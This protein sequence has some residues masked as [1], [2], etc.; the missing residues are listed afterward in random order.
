MTEEQILGVV[1]AVL[2]SNALTAWVSARTVR[3]RTDAET[4]STQVTTASK[5]V[6]T[7]NHQLQFAL[8]R[9]EKLE[10]AKEADR[11]KIHVLERA[12]DVDEQ[13]I[14]VLS[15]RITQLESAMAS[16]GLEIPPV[17]A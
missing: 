8:A 9:I 3:K 15:R 16:N 7:I 14:A 10:A 5:L 11:E 17:L 6:D 2:G 12:K 4:E 1:L 13:K